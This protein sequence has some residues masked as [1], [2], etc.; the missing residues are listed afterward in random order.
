MSEQLRIWVL[1]L[2]VAVPLFVVGLSC[3]ALDDCD[4]RRGEQCE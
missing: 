3:D 1:A 2:C 4:A